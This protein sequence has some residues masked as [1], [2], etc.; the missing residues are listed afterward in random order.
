M[1]ATLVALLLAAPGPPDTC[2]QDLAA[3]CEAIEKQCGHLLKAKGISLGKIKNELAKPA[4]AAR[5]PE[6]EWVVL[7]R[8]VARLRD[9]HASVLTTEKT[10][11]LKWPLPLLDKGLG[12]C[13]CE[14]GG[15]V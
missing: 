11:D 9:G 12:L 14:G 15:K 8:L 3:A 6:E 4:A 5:T 10:K 2:K 13:W 1:L 7:S